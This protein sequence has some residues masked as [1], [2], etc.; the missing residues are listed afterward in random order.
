MLSLKLQVEEYSYD[1]GS[2]ET[3]GVYENVAQGDMTNHFNAWLFDAER[4][5]GDHGIVESDYGWHIMEYIGEG[6]G[7]AWAANVERALKSADGDKMID[8][9]NDD[10]T[11]DYKV[12]AKINA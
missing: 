2:L 6:E 11:F 7:T 3:D 10:I 5:V 1:E 12:I 8:A 9:H 4:K